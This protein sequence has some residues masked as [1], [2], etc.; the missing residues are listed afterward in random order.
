MMNMITV[1]KYKKSNTGFTLIE[2]LV[3][4][5][6]VGIVASFAIPSF[7]NLIVSNRNTTAANELM[8]NLLLAKSEALK[9]SSNVTLCPSADQ[10]T[11]SGSSDYSTGWIVFLDCNDNNSTN[12][13]V[14]NCG[15]NNRE[16]IIKVRE[17]F[18]SMFINNASDTKITFQFSGRT[19]GNSTFNIGKDASN[20]KKRIV[21]NPVGR[22]RATSV[23]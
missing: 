17:G 19:G 1:S 6:I 9:R 14:A 16:E 12:D 4:I 18:D 15:P 2:I 22:V 5:A 23:N 21:I 11:C 8:A 10:S 3:T 20:V 7:N 13:A